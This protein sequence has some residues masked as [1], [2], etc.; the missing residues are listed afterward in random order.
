MGGAR[1][2]AERS[3]GAS[4]AF[5]TTPVWHILSTQSVLLRVWITYQGPFSWEG[6]K[7]PLKEWEQWII[8]RKVWLGLMELIDFFT[9]IIPAIMVCHAGQL[10]VIQGPRASLANCELNMSS[11]LPG[12]ADIHLLLASHLRSWR[13]SVFLLWCHKATDVLVHGCKNYFLFYSSYKLY[14]MIHWISLSYFSNISHFLSLFYP[15]SQTERRKKCCLA[16]SKELVNTFSNIN[17]LVTSSQSL[18]Y[19]MLCLYGLK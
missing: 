16:T 15:L 14:L 4:A 6:N 12:L 9:I 7:R 2:P 5:P 18:N 17:P 10:A 13:L 3:L 11:T 8:V 1:H 19:I